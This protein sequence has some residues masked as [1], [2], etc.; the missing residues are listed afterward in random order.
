M[1]VHNQADAERRME[2]KQNQG[3]LF[4]CHTVGKWW[5]QSVPCSERQAPVGSVAVHLCYVLSSL[6]LEAAGGLFFRA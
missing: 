1:L 4:Y 2:S 6:I 3:P 5:G